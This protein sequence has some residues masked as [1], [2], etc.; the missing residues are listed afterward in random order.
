M[1][2]ADANRTGGVD[3]RPLRLALAD[4]GAGPAAAMTAV[5]RMAAAGITAL[6]GEFHSA[7]AVPVS[8]VATRHALPYVCS[9]ATAD[10]VVRDNP[11][12]VFR[13]AAHQSRGWSHYAHH[14][15]DHGCRHAVLVVDPGEY[16]T[17]GLRALE[18]QFSRR[19]VQVSVVARSPYD[20][21]ELTRISATGV[22]AP[23]DA[24]LLL[25]VYP[26]PYARLLRAI[27]RCPATHVIVGDPAGRVAFADCL[28]ALGSDA[29]GIPY[30]AYLPSRLTSVGD[31]VRRRFRTLHGR[32]PSFVF[33]EGYD[34]V[35]TLAAALRGAGADRHAVRDALEGVQVEGTRGRIEF[36]AGDHQWLSPVRVDVAHP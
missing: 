28:R 13:L 7:V 4:T 31:R 9:S 17:E 18:E 8:S 1:A 11:A 32:E 19:G 3:G 29:A 30:L 5:E 27:R 35:L 16:W 23:T 26:E 34:L 25:V 2:V 10:A 33:L 6:V 15:A 22:A 20:E 21:D 36:S 14:L 24:V 12:W